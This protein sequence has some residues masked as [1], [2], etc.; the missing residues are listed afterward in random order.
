MAKVLTGMD[1]VSFS[2]GGV[3][4]R[5]VDDSVSLFVMAVLLLFEVL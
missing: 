4:I 3:G 5:T 1:E 2:K